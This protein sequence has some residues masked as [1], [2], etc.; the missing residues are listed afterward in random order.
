[1]KVRV[2]G[3]RRSARLG[4]VQ[5]GAGRREA[6]L[7]CGGE[8]GSNAGVSVD[9][10]AHR[11]ARRTG[12]ESTSAD[13]DLEGGY[14]FERKVMVRIEGDDVVGEPAVAAG[15]L[16]TLIWPNRARG[17]RGVHGSVLFLS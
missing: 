9:R 12:G 16:E 17:G 4:G 1:M 13:G 10:I 5:R 15:A 2:V 11:S 7:R 8:V 3:W 6:R 14:A